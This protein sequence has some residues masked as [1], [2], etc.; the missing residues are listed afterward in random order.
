MD[1]N[2]VWNETLGEQIRSETK[3]AMQSQTD[4]IRRTAEQFVKEADRHEDR[5]QRLEDTLPIMRREARMGFET[6]DGETSTYTYYVEVEDIPATR[7]AEAE[8]REMRDQAAQVRK[9]AKKL[10]IAADMLEGKIDRIEALYR[11]LFELTQRMDAAYAARMWEIKHEIAAYINKMNAIRDS[12]GGV[13]SD[14]F[15]VDD[16]R[17]L[18]GAAIGSMGL[19][20][21]EFCPTLAQIVAGIQRA[22]KDVFDPINSAT[23]N[24]YYTKDD[25]IIKG[26]YPLIFKRFYNAV[27]GLEG[28]VLGTNWTYNHNIRLYNN[29]EQ[30]HIVFDDGHV[31]TY[32]LRDTGF[33][34]APVD[35]ANVLLPKD[36][37][38][39]FVL[40]LSTLLQYHFNN[41]GILHYILDENGN[42]TALEYDGE[43]LKS[44]S[45]N[46]GSISF[47]YNESGQM[48]SVFDHTG[49]NVTF[50]YN[51]GQL[52]KVIH[53]SG[54]TIKYE[55]EGPGVI[56]KVIDPM[57]NATVNNEYDSE[58]RTVVQHLPDG[59]IA[60]M[61]YDNENMSTTVTEQNGNKITFFRDKSYRTT[62]AVYA[63]FEENYI[64]DA[65]TGLTGHAD[66]NNNIWWYGF[67]FSGNMTVRTDPLGNTIEAEYNAFNKP[68]KLSFANGAHMD[69]TY[70]EFGN[71]TSSTDPI[72][73]QTRCVIDETTRT[74]TLV[75]SDLSEH[76]LEMDERGN[77]VVATDSAGVKTLYEYD[78]LN[79]AIKATN[80]DGI[81]TLF[82]YNVDNNIT[83]VTDAMGNIRSY[84]YNLAGQVTHITDFDGAVIEYRY[85]SMG[86]VEEIIDASGIGTKATYDLMQN[87]T[88][89]TD[90]NGHTVYYEYDQYNRV[91]KTTD[92]EGNATTYEHDN[93]GNVTA[94][95]SPLGLRTEIAYDTLNRHRGVTMPDGA[96]TEFTYD[97]VGNLVYVADPLGNISTREYDLASQLVKLTDAMGN[98]TKFTY[99]SLGQ[100]ETITNPNGEYLTYSYYPGGRLKSV[101]LPGGECESYEYNNSGNISKIID[102][103]GYETILKYDVLDRVIESINP[104]GNSKKFAYNAIGRMTHLTDENGNTTQYKYSPMGDI[105][106][107]VDAAGHST[108]FAYDNVGRLTKQE[109][110]RIIEDAFSGAKQLE[111]QITTYE[112]NKNGQV[113]AV[114]S[115]LGDVIKYA[116][117]KDGN[118]TS[119]WDEEGLE[120]LYEYNLVGDLAKTTYFDGKTVEL[121]YNS[122]RHL[123]EMRDW[124]GTTT[125]ESDALGRVIKVTD[126]EGKQ[127]NYFWNAAGRREKLVYPD[128]TEVAYEYGASGNLSKVISGSD[129]TRYAYD[130]AGRIAERIL[131]DCTKTAYAYNPMGDIASIIHSKDGE[132]LDSFKYAHDPV[133]N[134]TQIEKQRMGVA[135]DSGVFKYD[136]DPL[137]RLIGVVSGTNGQGQDKKIFA[138]DSVGNRIVSMQNGVE[139]R[140]R[141][142][143]RNQLIE[144]FEAGANMEGSAA[145]KTDTI[146]SYLY[147]KRGNLAQVM[148]N[149]QL[150]A[151][152]TFDSANMMV[153][154]FTQ[155]KGTA[156]YAY[157]G[158]KNRVKK[159][160]KLSFH[161]GIDAMQ[162]GVKPPGIEAGVPDP[163]K[164]VRYILDMTQPYDN[165]LMT[166]DVMGQDKQSIRTQSFVWGDELLT[167]YS[168]G[169]SSG[170]AHHYLQDHLGSP[171]RLLGTDSPHAHLTY[172]APLAYDE[173]GVQ[174]VECAG[175]G[176]NHRNNP[177]GF[178]NPFG[179]TGY[180][181]DDVSGLHYA[182]ARYYKAGV[183]RFISE[184]PARA[185]LNWY[186]YCGGNPVGFVDPRGLDRIT[187]RR[188]RI[189]CD[190]CHPDPYN[191]QPP[192]PYAW[193]VPC[194]GTPSNT[195]V[196]VTTLNFS[197]M[198]INIPANIVRAFGPQGLGEHLV[199]AIERAI[200]GVVSG[201]SAAQ[202]TL[203]SFWLTGL[204]F[205]LG[206]Q[207]EYFRLQGV[208]HGATTEGVLKAVKLVESVIK[209]IKMPNNART[210]QIIRGFFERNN[211]PTL[212][213][214]HFFRQKS[215]GQ[216]D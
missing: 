139:T 106:E 8:I 157:N 53:P 210:D 117:D 142:N 186:D 203:D 201:N 43:L 29:R 214:L 209:L 149:G 81:A 39:G 78:D 130:M 196:T 57:G 165:L 172:N 168:D 124:L 200:F 80:G 41:K 76:K 87:K 207:A 59:G 178:S 162:P 108:K 37:S 30:V 180:Q 77:V 62:R 164:E 52:I 119:K 4:E 137:N 148:Q 133:G 13:P 154:A 107:I 61:E 95:I 144:T 194:R 16:V 156:E 27:G 126:F 93:N 99:T 31:E 2:F 206:L 171:I 143:A 58:G 115:P 54:A 28:G 140:Y 63:D 40:H 131:P 190:D 111:Y 22:A 96:K 14:P 17:A 48:S 204:Q 89:I 26:R 120:T 141:F 211:I 174:K 188:Y 150:A 163:C 33:Y 15:T 173:F 213:R 82:E 90:N 138:Y 195:F 88:S 94:V 105:V 51:E 146:S 25:L 84:E 187:V 1:I 151:S 212:I 56:S 72:E 202:P 85:N 177:S 35:R 152:Y 9:A 34:S 103:A 24:Y 83:R 49:R 109:Q 192:G 193:R 66:R 189:C 167:A 182:Q 113:V 122:L 161:A 60:R 121:S 134:I 46:C 129:V 11:E 215:L 185:Q 136:Y 5:A 65:K 169:G 64:Y 158:F 21:W 145:V 98:E 32:T 42:E 104:L 3:R 100:I 183:G 47:A 191:F 97:K 71:L 198:I 205:E 38:D 110:C 127:V 44:V 184:D 160:E 181:T 73:R 197:S 45:N 102:A 23:G 6:V 50:E 12:F 112:R 74:H 166:Q 91:V 92:Q 67:D 208:E 70:D 18:M 135:G 155:G 68:T 179:F 10:E 114:T 75:Q 216:V 55:Y 79:R 153:S 199:G 159:M 128:G 175:D 170:S 69:F 36:D 147:D 125:I 20:S 7:A 116:Y 123:S 118:T 101:S 86:Q 176:I 19:T 132:I